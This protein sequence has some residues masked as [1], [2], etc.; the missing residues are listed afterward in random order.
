[1]RMIDNSNF[2]YEIKDSKIDKI[3]ISIWYKLSDGS[4]VRIEQKSP[5][6]IYY[7]D[8]IVDAKPI[9]PLPNGWYRIKG[10]LKRIFVVNG[11]IQ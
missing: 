1:M 3:L 6:D 7:G 2:I 10:R 9:F 11:T 5:R 4:E 8:K